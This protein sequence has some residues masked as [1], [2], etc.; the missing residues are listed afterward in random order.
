MNKQTAIAEGLRF[1]GHFERSFNVEKLKN[2]AKAIRKL[3]K[4]RVCMVSVDGGYSLYADERY[5][6]I[7]ILESALRTVNQEKA[8]KEHI[9]A[10]YQKELDELVQNT[11]RA[12]ADAEDVYTKYPDLRTMTDVPDLYQYLRESGVD[13]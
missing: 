1:T 2:V 10:R 3:Y 11:Q 6:S 7:K 9:M 12:A 8:A 5:S 13:F 4:C